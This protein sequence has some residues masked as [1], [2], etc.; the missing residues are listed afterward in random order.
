[1]K[2]RMVNDQPQVWDPI[3]K[4]YLQFTPEENVRQWVIQTLVSAGYPLSRIGA[5]KQFALYERKKRF[6]LCV[7][8]PD[9]SPFLLIECKAAEIEL[10][11]A[12]LYQVAGYQTKIQANWFAIT[13]GH[14]ILC[15]NQNGEML[16]DAFPLPQ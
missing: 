3:R 1:M 2:I 10:T 8:L 16:T 15:I 7:F 9:G 5:E 14:Q 12:H 6:D 13:N 4:K 11:E